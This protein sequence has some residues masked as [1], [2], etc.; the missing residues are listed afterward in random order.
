MIC[1]KWGSEAK[2]EEKHNIYHTQFTFLFKR[3]NKKVTG[4]KTQNTG[5]RDVHLY[6]VY[7]K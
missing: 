5:V 1:E 7:L 3:L 2:L 6:V 4:K